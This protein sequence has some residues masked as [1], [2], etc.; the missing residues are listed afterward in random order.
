GLLSHSDEQAIETAIARVEER[1]ATELVVAVVRK[2]DDYWQWRVVSAAGWGVAAAIA[3][4]FLAPDASPLWAILLQV[5]VAGLVYF[6][7]GLGPFLRRFVPAPVLDDAAQSR[8]MLLF[9]ERGLHNTRERTGLLVFLSELEH[10]VVIL[11]DMGIH[12]AVG[13]EGLRF[14]VDDVVRHVREG[15]TVEGILDVIARLEPVLVEKAPVRPG[16]VNEIPNR[17]IRE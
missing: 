15:R 2:S 6:L 7:T 9:A 16:D 14:Y 13:D 17:I 8:A 1:S 10:R 11:G 5:P 4:T 12:A 3:F